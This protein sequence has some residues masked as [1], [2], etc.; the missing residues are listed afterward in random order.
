MRDR[1]GERGGH[2]SEVELNP[3]HA[4][5]RHDP[6]RVVA[7]VVEDPEDVAAGRDGVVL[8]GELRTCCEAEVAPLPAEPPDDLAAVPVDL[9]DRPRMPPRDQQ[10]PVGVK[11]DG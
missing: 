1:P 9:V 8:P 7:L 3:D 11:A 6:A 10:V 5:L 4:R 2:V